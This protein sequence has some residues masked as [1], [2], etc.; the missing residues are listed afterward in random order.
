M[1]DPF[2]GM[3]DWDNSNSTLGEGEST[4]ED[5]FDANWWDEDDSNSTLGDEVGMMEDSFGVINRDD[6]VG[7]GDVAEDP[8]PTKVPTTTTASTW[9]PSMAPASTNDYDDNTEDEEDSVP[10]NAPSMAPTMV[11]LSYQDLILTNNQNTAATTLKSLRG[12]V[13][14]NI[15]I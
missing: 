1:D 13:V 4:M 11:K 9:P 7:E 12:A 2:S 6:A 14:H 10:S 8:V 5:P 3:Q 15:G